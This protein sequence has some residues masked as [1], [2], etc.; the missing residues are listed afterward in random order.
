MYI[1]AKTALAN[2]FGFKPKLNM[3]YSLTSADF[4][5]V[6]KIRAS[7]LTYLSEKKL[8]SLIHASCIA[9]QNKLPGVF[10][11]TGCALGGS[12]IML[13]LIKGKGRALNVYDVFG[14]IP[15]PTADDTPEVHERYQKIA[16]GES[17]GI[18]GEKYYGYVDNL[19]DHVKD[20]FESFDVDL[21]QNSVALIKGLVQDTLVVDQPVALAHIDVD[22]YE[23][24]KTCL[25]RIY[26]KL[27][28][29]GAIVLDDYNVWGGCKKATDEYFSS[30][31][32][33][34]VMDDS[35]VSMKITKLS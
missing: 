27:I 10:I 3:D 22:W 18:A 23:P 2:L 29:G 8:Q 20:N 1:K 13:S 6:K 11:E 32:G 28:V 17:R 25:E 31:K 30:V 33:E 35:A 12:A 7:K 16:N 34:Y 5:L 15:E 26:P 21:K 9:E 19:Y 4:E 14:M 24:V